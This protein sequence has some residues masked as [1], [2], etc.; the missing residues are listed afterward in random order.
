MKPMQREQMTHEELLNAQGYHIC[1]PIT[2]SM[3]PMIR[4]RR[5]SALFVPPEGRLKR[6]D[7][8]LYRADGGKAVM[9][10]VLQV[11]PEG[12]F[13]R[14]DNA[15]TGEFVREGQVF[16][17]MKGFYRDETF[18]EADSPPYRLYARAW[19]ALHPLLCLY[20]RLRRHIH[21]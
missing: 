12:Y 14:G 8:A 1:S 18:I 20:K 6:Y 15:L 16:G 21:I 19:V 4:V 11:L 3:R 7:V 2:G 5:D 13:I 9:H 17:V 10:R